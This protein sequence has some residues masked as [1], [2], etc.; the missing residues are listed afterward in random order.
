MI[1]Q[2]LDDMGLGLADGAGRVTDD[3]IRVYAKLVAGGAAELDESAFSSEGLPFSS[4][5]TTADG[6]ARVA[7]R[8]E[9]AAPF[10]RRADGEGCRKC[11]HR[12][13]GVRPNQMQVDFVND[14]IRHGSILVI[15]GD[16]VM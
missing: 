7:A 5:C 11:S 15:A 2:A 16:R 6:K 9:F 12:R 1:S 14:Q 10:S 4:Q 3:I 13:H 8:A